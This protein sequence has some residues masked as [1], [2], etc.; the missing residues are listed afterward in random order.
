DLLAGVEGGLGQVVVGDVVGD[1]AVV[2]AGGLV[3]AGLV[4]QLVAGHGG[5]Q[6]QQLI[7]RVEVVLAAGGADEE[8]EQDRLAD[9]H[10]VTGAAQAGVGETEAD[11]PADGRLVAADQL[12]G[13]RLVAAADPAN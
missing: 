10:R 13:S 6:A 4:E 1:Q 9:V 3:L 7:G 12:G 2:T 8:A 11:G 5:Q